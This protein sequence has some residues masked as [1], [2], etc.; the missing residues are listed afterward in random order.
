MG[1]IYH[2]C[3]TKNADGTNRI[4]AKGM[5]CLTPTNECFWKDPVDVKN[6]IKTRSQTENQL[7]VDY[8]AFDDY[9]TK[10]QW[11]ERWL[12]GKEQKNN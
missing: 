6:K 9:M 1:C 3:F 5:K 2:G 8:K 7:M 11:V 12:L 10:K 4:I